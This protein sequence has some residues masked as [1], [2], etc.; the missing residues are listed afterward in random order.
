M[1]FNSDN[2]SIAFYIIVLYLILSFLRN[3]GHQRMPNSIQFTSFVY[4]FRNYLK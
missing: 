3:A 4:N 2:K 1:K